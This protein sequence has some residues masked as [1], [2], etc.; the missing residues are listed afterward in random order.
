MDHYSQFQHE[1]LAELSRHRLL[2]AFASRLS[3]TRFHPPDQPAP[4]IANGA[5]EHH[6]RRSVPAHAG[7]REPRLADAKEVGYLLRAT[8]RRSGDIARTLANCA[9]LRVV[10]HGLEDDLACVELR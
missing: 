7:L 4:A 10:S 9:A 8:L 2:L 5:T 1:D 3:H 6:V